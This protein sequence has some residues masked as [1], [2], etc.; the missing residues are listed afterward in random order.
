MSD[1]DDLYGLV[2]EFETPD[3]LV[4]AA[5]RAREA[6]YRHLGAYTPFPVHGLPEAIGFRRT[7]LP[8]VVLI[9]G[10]LGA[11]GGFTM[12]YWISVIEYPLNIGGRPL[13]SWPSFIPVT[14]ELTVL[15]AS[16]FAVLGMLA[17]NGLPTPHHP[18]F[19][20]P[21]F[22]RA[23]RDRFFLT[24]QRRDPRF[25]MKQTRQ[26]LEDLKPLGVYE[27]PLRDAAT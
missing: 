3:E 2:A 9:G 26:F 12:Q 11:V 27:V 8:L 5:A 23:T 1:V 4:S 25:E 22:A 10:I 6:G 24:V 16:L 17:L 14:F 18:L 7:M 15:V 21:Q 20:V 19:G 13:N